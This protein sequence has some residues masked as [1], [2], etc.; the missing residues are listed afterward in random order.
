MR[1]LIYH[2]EHCKAIYDYIT[3][4]EYQETIIKEDHV[5]LIGFEDSGN[6][7]I[8]VYFDGEIFY[9]RRGAFQLLPLNPFQIVKFFH[10][11]GYNPE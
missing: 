1:E 6:S 5:K 4:G 2:Q 8:E 10:E 11:L 3:G 7:E 9:K